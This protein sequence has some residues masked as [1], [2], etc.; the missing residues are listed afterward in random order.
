MD[1]AVVGLG[2]MGLNMALRLL[3]GGHRVVVYN[4]SDGPVETAEAEG[5]EAAGSLEEIAEL[6]DPP[7]VAW[8]MLPAGDVT[9]EHLRA[10]HD[11]LGEGDL[12]AEGAN[13]H[14]RDSLRRAQEAAEAGLRFVDVGVSGGIW[15]LENGYSLMAGGPTGDVAD[16]E[17]ALKTLAPAEDE[18]WGRVGP[19]GAGH[20][21]KMVHN[22]IEYGMMQAMAEGF[23]VMEAKRSFSLED[24][25]EA[26]EGQETADVGTEDVQL[27][28]GRVA[29]VWRS[30]SVVQSWLLDLTAEVLQGR[31]RL[32][33]IAPYVPDSGE[34]RWTVEE[35]VRLGVPAAAISAGLF[36]RFASQSER[37]FPDRMLSAMRGQFGGHPVKGDASEAGADGLHED[38]TIDVVPG[39]VQTEGATT[40]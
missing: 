1:L 16:L 22:G 37:G 4:R 12:I 38:G 24:G 14:Y 13:A 8:T 39:G 31:P 35:A 34:G 30:G 26:P 11:V 33:G 6:L 27:D 15:G 10:L 23:A 7:R 5:A 19:V 2:K 40:R 18:G 29:E 32:E 21:V 9:D 20:F 3:R 25:A 28:L 36:E 17:P